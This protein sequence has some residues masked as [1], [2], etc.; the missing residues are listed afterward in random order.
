MKKEQLS[1]TE[2]I[3]LL[4]RSSQERMETLFE[5]YA[6]LLW[7]VAGQYLHDPEDIK[8]CVNDT[9]MEFYRHRNRFEPQKGSL[10]TYLVAIARNLAVSR[11]RNNEA[12]AASAVLQDIPDGTD[13]IGEAE[14]RMDL[15]RAIAALEPMDA[16]LIRMKYYGGMTLREIAESMNL[17]YETVK[18]RHQRSLS[19]MKRFL[20]T[21]LILLLTGLLAACAYMALRHFGIIP[22]Y[23][24]AEEPGMVFWVLTEPVETEFDLGTVTV[25]DVILMDG[26]I[27]LSMNIDFLDEESRLLFYD[28]KAQVDFNIPS[29]CALMVVNGTAY[30]CNGYQA[31]DMRGPDGSV[32]YNVTLFTP[33]SPEASWAGS[34]YIPIPSPEN[35]MVE[36]QWDITGISVSFS[37]EPVVAGDADD[38]SCVYHE[39][40]GLAAI[41]R[42]AEGKLQVELYGLPTGE[43]YTVEPK[44]LWGYYM[45]GRVGDITLTGVDGREITGQY[46]PTAYNTYSPKAQLS[47]W[48]FGEVEPGEYILHVPYIFLT[49]DLGRKNGE[50]M[51]VDLAAGVWEDTPVEMPFGSL[52]VTDL[53]TLGPGDSLRRW[54][55]ESSDCLQRWYITLEW[56][57]PEGLDMTM[58]ICFL[59][60]DTETH[61]GPDAPTHYSGVE[62]EFLEEDLPE[63]VFRWYIGLPEDMEYF[64]NGIGLR[65]GSVQSYR[66]NQSF[67]LKITVE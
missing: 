11:Y 4:E 48:D 66:W 35:G 62:T 39:L 9:F 33:F 26:T 63:N 20:I 1:E 60:S 49:T 17:P 3:D 52:W 38:Y 6:G 37:L 41:P 5:R 36:L 56:E 64:L 15:E 43:G 42:Q 54:Q 50:E 28:R 27:S 29:T 2:L 30:A 13:P 31:G 58:A 14:K 45:E 19:R 61:F 7:S 16:E 10:K 51:H 57:P 65:T 44:L 12:H 53:E 34:P 25:R 21:S 59:E 24:T 55:M 22:G 47:L 40:A 18:K 8:E 23:G 67:E 46:V 32:L